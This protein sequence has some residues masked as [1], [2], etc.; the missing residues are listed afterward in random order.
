MDRNVLHLLKIVM[1]ILKITPLISSQISTYVN[2]VKLHSS[3]TM[4]WE[5]VPVAV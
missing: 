5:V 4:M 3:S 1:L 2:N